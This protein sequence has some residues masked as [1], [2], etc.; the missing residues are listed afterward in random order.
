[1]L[2]SFAAAALALAAVQARAAPWSKTARDPFLVSCVGSA[3]GQGVSEDEAKGYC[4]CAAQTLERKYGEKAFLAATARK[5]PGVQADVQ[6]AVAACAKQ[7]VEQRKAQLDALGIGE[8]WSDVF[9]GAFVGSCVDGAVEKGAK[10]QKAEAYCGC[11]SR[12][13]EATYSE[14]AFTKAS[15]SPNE[16]Y[17]ADV[18]GAAKGCAKE[19]Q[20]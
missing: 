20:P 1:M 6:N 19:L 5:S 2:R 9:R 13:L 16:R 17:N 10:K 18:I 12:K 3:S 7:V 4:E 8:R 15:F 11:V 14:V